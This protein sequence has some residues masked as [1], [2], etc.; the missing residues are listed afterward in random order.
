M[1]GTNIE[2]RK[3]GK[4]SRIYVMAK[5]KERRSKIYVGIKNKKKEKKKRLGPMLRQGREEGN[6]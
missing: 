6:D 3:R 5:K 2:A 4:R 1:I